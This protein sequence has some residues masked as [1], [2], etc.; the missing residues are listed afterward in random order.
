MARLLTLF[1]AVYFTVPLVSY[2]DEFTVHALFS[3]KTFNKNPNGWN[4]SLRLKYFKDPALISKT[5][6]LLQKQP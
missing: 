1:V 6:W 5:E 2:Q 4:D 3:S